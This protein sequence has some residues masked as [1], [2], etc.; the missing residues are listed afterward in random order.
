QILR[1]L[2]LI[3]PL[4]TDANDKSISFLDYEGREKEIDRKVKDIIR[5]KGTDLAKYTDEEQELAA[6][7]YQLRLLQDSSRNNVLLR[8]IPED[9]SNKDSNWLS[10]WSVKK[11]DKTDAEKA[12]YLDIWK[13]M[14]N[15]YRDHDETA[16]VNYTNEALKIFP[17]QKLKAEIIYNK[18][19]LIGAAEKLYLLAF[20]LLLAGS[21]LPKFKTDKAAFI[22]LAIGLAA[23]GIHIALRIYILGRPPVGTLYESIL[24]VSLI[25]VGGLALF[26]L[27]QRTS[28]G[29]LLGSICGLILLVTAEGFTGE[30]TM[31]TLV[32]VLNTNFWLGTHVLCISAG[33]GLCLI[34][35]LVSHYYLGQKFLNKKPDDFYAMLLRN[36]KTLSILALLFTTIGTILGGIWADQSWGRFWGWDP[37]E[38]GALLIVIW[39]IWLLHGRIS[40][41]ISDDAFV[42]GGAFLSIVVVLAWFGV[43]LLNVGLHSYGFISGVAMGI[44]IFCAAEILVIGGLWYAVRRKAIA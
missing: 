8:I 18:L 26:S 44:G 23:H 40:R 4:D 25:T 2:T 31:S 42:V 12:A 39:L 11:Q 5:R 20:V 27:W 36:L 10:P 1:S 30:D 13:N 19:N 43:N 24:F 33:Y 34:T 21:L 37:K 32:A 17:A 28:T 38:N 22:A 7:S 6:L 9:Q 41:H 35:S 14:A 15:A 3:L 29:T 16:W